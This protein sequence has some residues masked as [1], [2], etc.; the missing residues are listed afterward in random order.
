MGKTSGYINYK[1]DCK[2]C[3]REDTIL[4]SDPTAAQWQEFTR[5]TQSGATVTYLLCPTHAAGF[6]ALLK[7]QDAAVQSFIEKGE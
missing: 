1:C 5:T 7:S 2:A 3:K 6:A 4:P